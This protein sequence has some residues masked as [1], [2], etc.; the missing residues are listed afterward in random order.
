VLTDNSVIKELKTG[1]SRYYDDLYRERLKASEKLRPTR[2][3]SHA[4]KLLFDHAGSEDITVQRLLNLNRW[5][6]SFYLDNQHIILRGR[7]LAALIC[8]AAILFQQKE[9][10]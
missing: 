1:C 10:T 6:V 4:F 8:A 3:L 2:N 9:S 7:G 5:Q